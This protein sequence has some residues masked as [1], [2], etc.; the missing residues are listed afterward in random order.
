LFQLSNQDLVTVDIRFP[1]AVICLIS[2][3][4]YHGLTTQIPH[5]I[6]V[7]VPRTS[8]LPLLLKKKNFEI[9]ESN[10]QHGY[11][12]ERIDDRQPSTP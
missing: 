8:R 11:E 4:A 7:A 6:F 5:Y 3:L 2:A 12:K 1:N 9:K 10:Y